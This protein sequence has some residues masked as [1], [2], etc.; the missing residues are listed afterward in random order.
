MKK[1][2]TSGPY[3]TAGLHLFVCMQQIRFSCNNAQTCEL[4]QSEKWISLKKALSM[5]DVSLVKTS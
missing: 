4:K 2:I 3:L 1:F 5:K